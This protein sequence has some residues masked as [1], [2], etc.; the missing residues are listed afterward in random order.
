[1]GNDAAVADE[2][3]A[4]VVRAAKLVDHAR[5]A[6]LRPCAPRRPGARSALP[7]RLPRR[8]RRASPPSVLFFAELDQLLVVVVQVEGDLGDAESEAV[9]LVGQCDAVI[10]ARAGFRPADPKAAQWL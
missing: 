3:V 4:N 1:M 5:C 9:F 6:D 2:E 8:P 7:A 10:S